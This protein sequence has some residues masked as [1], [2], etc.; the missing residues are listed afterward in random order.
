VRAV[1]KRVEVEIRQWK[2]DNWD[3]LVSFTN[4]LVRHPDVTERK[5]LR[6]NTIFVFDR[7]HD[8][9]I[10]LEENDW[11][12]QGPQGEFYPIK[13]DVFEATYDLI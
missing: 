5:A 7:L 1:K 9:W 8:T 2:V 11:I 12:I 3:Q 4:H 10:P 13:N 6:T